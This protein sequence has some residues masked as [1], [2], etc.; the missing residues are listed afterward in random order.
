MAWCR[1][2]GDGRRAVKISWI[3]SLGPG[4]ASYRYRAQIPAEQVHRFTEIHCSLNAGV[5]DV[6]VFA[7][8][9]P[10]DLQTIRMARNDGARV[11]VDFCDDHFD[12]PTL[13]PVYRDMAKQADI[14]TCPTGTM[15]AR[16]YAATGRESV[17]IGDPYEMPLIPPHADGPKTIWFGHQRNLPEITKWFKRIDMSNFML[18]TG[19]T[20]KVQGYIPWSVENLITA[21]SEA[22]TALLPVSEGGEYKSPNRLVNALRAGCFVVT[23]NVP[24]HKEF[25]EFVW[26]G[27]LET[28]LKWFRA[29]ESDLNDRVLAGQA[30]IEKY[31]P[32]RIGAQWAQLIASL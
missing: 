2:P 25:R 4:A 3:H 13:G 23:K 29:F 21:L 19:E 1:A 9:M 11:V 22:N 20:T 7:K 15:G 30:Y 18:V 24:A 10:D 12:H 32:E 28:G 6:V 14:I 27:G 5:A 17:T 26:T 8:P 31:S 16:I